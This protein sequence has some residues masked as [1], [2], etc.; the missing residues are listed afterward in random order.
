MNDTDLKYL[1]SVF[2]VAQRSREH[3]NHPFGA[4]LVNADGAQ[5]LEAENTVVSNRDCTGHAEINL[6][7][8]ASCMFES[9]QLAKCT[10]YASTEPCA[11]CSGAIYWSG[12]SRLVYGLST[13]RLS[14]II[15]DNPANP[16]LMLS[17]RDVFA[18]GRLTITIEG[19]AHE[20]EAELVH[21]GFWS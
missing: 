18:K 5:L 8:D 4:I 19:P 11:M 7:R 17:C 3:G 14:E 16:T 13:K 20:S 9:S 2:L 1:R 21:E 15:H 12:I 6:V 10:L